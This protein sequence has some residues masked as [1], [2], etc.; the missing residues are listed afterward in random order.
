MN[1]RRQLQYRELSASEFAV[2]PG[3]DFDA[4]L[5]LREG[6]YQRGNLRVISAHGY[7][8]DCDREPMPHFSSETALT[9]ID[10]G[11]L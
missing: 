1:Q 8:H 9:E 6:C 7:V 10:L 4:D 3:E 2:R 11:Y 5:S